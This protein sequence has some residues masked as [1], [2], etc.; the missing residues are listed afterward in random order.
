[1][2]LAHKDII[3]S[4]VFAVFVGLLIGLD[5]FVHQPVWKVIDHLFDDPRLVLALKDGNLKYIFT[6]NH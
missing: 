6:F 3:I 1:M 4:S 5:T 2:Y